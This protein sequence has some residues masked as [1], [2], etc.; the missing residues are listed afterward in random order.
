M[1]FNSLEYL[2]FLPIVFLL[3]FW[4]EHKYRWIILL[5][6]SCA[7]YMSWNWHYIG[8]L[9][10]STLTDYFC[11]IQI[12]KTDSLSVKKAY[13][14]FSLVINLGLLFTFK[15]FNFFIDNFEYMFQSF[16]IPMQIP[17][18]RLILP[19]GI[20]FYTFQ[21]LSYTIDVYRGVKKVETNLGIFLVYITFFPQLLAGPIERSTHLMQQFYI[22]QK[23]RYDNI[24][25]GCRQMLWGF[26]KKIIIADHLAIYV[27]EIYNHPAQYSAGSLLLAAVFFSFQIYCDFSGYSDIAIGTARLFG[28]D[29]MKNFN[30]PYL[31]RSLREFWKRWHISLSTWFKDYLYVPLGGNQVSKWLWYRNI[32]IVFIV[33]GIWH[34]ANWT[35]LLW[36]LTH[37]L[38]L[39]ME[40]MTVE[41]RHRFYQITHLNKSGILLKTIKTITCF[42]FVSFTWVLFRANNM[43]DLS[44]ILSRI[45]YDISKG[46]KGNFMISR[47]ES[48]D[49]GFALVTIGFLFLIELI[50]RKFNLVLF[51]NQF[52][53]WLRWT[54][55]GLSII[56]I[57]LCSKTDAQE[58]IYFR[59]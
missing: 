42:S 46:T 14:S 34:G 19:V 17:Y 57:L 6:A 5:V 20:S 23:L 12:S 51:L 55:Y 11:A 10:V 22:E 45:F 53:A 54:V 26:L 58:F 16:N 4:L 47:V 52:N 18:L 33:S 30:A 59:F 24:S 28:I 38:I 56:L 29:L 36:G 41:L 27:N 43:N 31:A 1:S 40:A 3:Y 50:H 21:A 13:L 35:F 48:F 49:I 9:L 8:I 39:V 25:S 37:G 44:L 32:M 2:I 7:Y 15:Y